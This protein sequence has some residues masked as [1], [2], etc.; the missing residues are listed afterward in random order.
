MVN[1]YSRHTLGDNSDIQKFAQNIS[2]LTG[3]R[4]NIYLP[5]H[6]VNIK[7]GSTGLRG[8]DQEF[9]VSFNKGWIGISPNGNTSNFK[10]IEIFK[11][12]YPS[13]IVK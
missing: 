10:K 4:L 13:V 6:F 1:L 7:A 2:K 12:V 9:R 5:K 8:L 11:T 3:N